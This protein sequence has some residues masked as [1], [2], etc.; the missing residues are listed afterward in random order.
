MRGTPSCA[1][2]T[3]SA[4]RARS[5]STPARRT[6][7]PGRAAC[8]TSC[9]RGGAR[10]TAPRASSEPALAHPRARP[11]ASRR[12]STARRPRAP[13]TARP[14]SPR[15]R[16]TGRRAHRRRRA[17]RSTRARHPEHR[18]HASPAVRVDASV[19]SPLPADRGGRRVPV[20]VATLGRASSTLVIYPPTPE[21]SWVPRCGPRRLG[22]EHRP[23]RFVAS[24]SVSAPTSRR[25]PFPSPRTVAGSS[26]PTGR[27]PC[28]RGRRTA[29]EDDG[30]RT[31]CWT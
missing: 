9:A 30:C 1:A 28:R 20:L 19:G 16:D 15:G 23:A 13:L 3:P 27:Y 24:D 8:S 18:A 7:K 25:P 29:G 14:T 4:R 31:S 11:G 12:R 26:R 5:R 17:V 21:L 2:A 6:T 22:R 10:G